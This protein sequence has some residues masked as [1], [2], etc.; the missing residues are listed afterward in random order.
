MPTRIFSISF[1]LVL[2]FSGSGLSYLFS[3]HMARVHARRNEYQLSDRTGECITLN[4]VAYKK[5]PKEKISDDI[6]EIFY[7]NS[8]YDVY[9]TT[10]NTDGSVN[11]FARRDER[12]NIARALY[13]EDHLPPRRSSHHNAPFY[14]FHF[15]HQYNPAFLTPSSFLMSDIS[16]SVRTISNYHPAISP[17]PENDFA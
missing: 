12:E 14:S 4:A 17:P 13:S 7:E 9:L 1:L 3:T 5:L 15:F 16:F 2:F 10:V 6:Y 8:K 11:L